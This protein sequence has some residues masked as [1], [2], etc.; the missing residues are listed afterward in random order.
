MGSMNLD[1]AEHN[2]I[3]PRIVQV[4]GLG[5]I[6]VPV[7][8]IVFRFIPKTESSQGAGLYALV[9]NEGG[10]IGIA[11]VS[12]MLQRRSQVF[13]T[14]LGQHIGASDATVQNAIAQ[15]SA[16]PGNAADTH[17]FALAELYRKMQE[18]ASLLAY[19]DQFKMLCVIMVLMLPLVF[20][21]KRPPAQKHIELDAH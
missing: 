20:F 15:L 3:I 9:R 4:M 6:T 12:T 5:L 19:M 2:F 21:L 1:V 10:S 18:Q 13:Q 7:S 16:V 17:Y 8:T 11:L 14:V